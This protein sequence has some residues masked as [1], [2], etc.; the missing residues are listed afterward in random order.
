[1]EGA[2][3]SPGALGVA[4]HDPL[5]IRAVLSRLIAKNVKFYVDTKG[6]LSS[7]YAV[8]AK[9]CDKTR[10]LLKFMLLGE[11]RNFVKYA[12]D[13][14]S[15][16]LEEFEIAIAACSAMERNIITDSSLR[17]MPYSDALKRKDVLIYDADRFDYVFGINSTLTYGLLS[18]LV[19]SC[20]ENMIMHK[21]GKKL[22]DLHNDQLTALMRHYGEMYNF[23]VSDQSRA[24][25]TA[26]KNTGELDLYIL[27]GANIPFSVIECLRAN[28]FGPENAVVPEHLDKLLHHYDKLGFSK[29]FLVTYCESGDFDSAFSGYLKIMEGINENPRF[30]GKYKASSVCQNEARPNIRQLITTHL[31]EGVEVQVI[32]Y[33]CD[34]S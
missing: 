26:K 17:Y 15:S 18:K 19:M 9:S 7:E 8:K 29:N 6:V 2:V 24:G 1:M 5:T 23:H 33:F 31:R 13:R 27:K 28:S 32:H 34:F 4:S 14:G 20:L 11:N 3:L 10:T 25:G 22:E 12:V 16:S 30:T 21:A